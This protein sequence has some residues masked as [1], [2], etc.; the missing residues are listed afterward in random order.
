MSAVKFDQD[1]IRMD[2]IPPAVLFDLA[3][4]LMHGAKKYGDRNWERGMRW[5]RPYA[6]ALRHMMTWWGGQDEDPEDR[7]HHLAHAL[8]NLVFLLQYQRTV[9]NLDDRPTR[10]PSPRVTSEPSTPDEAESFS[11]VSENSGI[12]S[13]KTLS[14]PLIYV[15]G[16]YSDWRGPWFVK[17]KVR[18]AEWVAVKLMQAG[19]AVICPHTMTHN[20]D[21][22][23][24]Y[25]GFID[26][27]LE[28]VKR[29]DAVMLLPGWRTSNGAQAEK[30]Q[31]DFHGIPVFESMDLLCDAFP[32]RP[33]PESPVITE[34]PA[35]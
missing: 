32:N 7:L 29:C 3:T 28:I 6:A 18:G 33:Q 25:Q 30:A 13:L 10:R 31:A 16:P 22:T 23:V 24:D 12:G 27:D 34:K 15:A 2:L 17:Q 26:R 21:G 19:F 5:S 20:W 14:Y 11:T 4:V 1:K 8:C 9:P 35:D